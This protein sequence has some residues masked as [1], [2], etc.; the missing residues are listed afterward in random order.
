MAIRRRISSIKKPASVLLRK[1]TQVHDRSPT[2]SQPQ[3]HRGRL[4]ANIALS[5][6]LR[7][8][9]LPS[10]NLEPQSVRTPSKSGETSLSRRTHI[11]MLPTPTRLLLPRKKVAMAFRTYGEWWIYGV[12][13][14]QLPGWQGNGDKGSAQE[15]DLDLKSRLM[16][17]SQTMS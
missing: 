8:N 1:R 2:Q 17:P 7:L 16:L 15:S 14:Q 12:G 9:L 11:S 3:S 13:C 10:K 5:P 6:Q 4:L